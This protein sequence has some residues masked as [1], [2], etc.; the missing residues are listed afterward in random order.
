MDKDKSKPQFFPISQILNDTCMV[1][2]NQNEIHSRK[3]ALRC[4][5]IMEF[6]LINKKTSDNILPSKESNV[7]STTENKSKGKRKTKTNGNVLRGR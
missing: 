5:Y 1:C 6:T 2:Y 3:Q 7:D 4:K